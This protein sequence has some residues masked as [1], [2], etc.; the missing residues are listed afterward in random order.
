MGRVGGGWIFISFICKNK[1]ICA[2][3]K[4]GNSILDS[5]KEKKK[6][7][8]AICE[9]QLRNNEKRKSSKNCQ[10]NMYQRPCE[11]LKLAKNP[12]ATSYNFNFTPEFNSL[13]IFS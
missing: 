4:I 7:R 5:L 13:L 3:L 6:V 10:R 9:N 8:I 12:R 2:K 1:H 11:R